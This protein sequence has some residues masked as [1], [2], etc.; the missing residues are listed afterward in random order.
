MNKTA[1]LVDGGFFLKRY[2]TIK[3]LS[4]LDPQKT[5]KDLINICYK[6]L[7]QGKGV[8]KDLYRIYYYDC[9][10]YGEK[11]H[12]PITKKHIDFSKSEIY[13]FRIA[14]F[15]EL[16]KSRKVAL[17]LGQIETRGWQLRPNKV[18][19]LLKGDIQISDLQEQDAILDIGQKMVDTKIGL[20]IATITLKK[21]ADQ[22]ILISGD[23]DFVPAS[24]L[25][26]TEGVDFI[27]DPMW[28]PIKDHLFEHIDGLQTKI[29]RPKQ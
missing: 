23:S 4:S 3:K 19:A 2:K 15:E 11:Q 14:F 7:S 6:H 12:N 27:L 10:P 5:A 20:D 1:I 28:N 29:H 24:K 17:R 26:R 18:K 21:Q 13:K 22:I 25:A 8:R 9:M 16:K